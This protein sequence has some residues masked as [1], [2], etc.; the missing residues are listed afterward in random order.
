[1]ESISEECTKIF[2]APEI[3]WSVGYFIALF[4]HNLLPVQETS[5]EVSR[6]KGI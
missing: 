5:S 3:I 2:P 4:W 6:K 1:M